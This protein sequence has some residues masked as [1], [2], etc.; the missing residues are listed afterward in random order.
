M[1]IPCDEGQDTGVYLTEEEQTKLSEN[2]D[3]LTAVMYP[4]RH[5]QFPLSCQMDSDGR[6]MATFIDRMMST[7]MVFK[8]KES[9]V[10]PTG[11]ASRHKTKVS[12]GE[13]TDVQWNGFPAWFEQPDL[14]KL[15]CQS[16][17]FAANFSDQNAKEAVLTRLAKQKQ[18][19]FHMWAEQK[20]KG[21]SA[22]SSSSMQPPPVSKTPSD[23]AAESVVEDQTLP[24]A[25]GGKEGLELAEEQMREAQ[26]SVEKEKA[27][28]ALQAA[29]YK[30]ESIKFVQAIN[31]YSVLEDNL[32]KEPTFDDPQGKRVRTE[33]TKLFLTSWYKES[34]E[35]K[36]L[37]DELHAKNLC[38][39]GKGR[40]FHKANPYIPAP[41]KYKD[42]YERWYY[43]IVPKQTEQHTMKSQKYHID[44]D[45]VGSTV[46][47]SVRGDQFYSTLLIPLS[48]NA[49]E[50]GTEVTTVEQTDIKTLTGA[51][52]KPQGPTE[53]LNK[54]GYGTLFRGGAWHRGTVNNNMDRPRVMLMQ[55]LSTKEKDENEENDFNEEEERRKKKKKPSTPPRPKSKDAQSS[56]G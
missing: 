52:Q 27:N 11:R 41:E 42:L 12:A 13:V 53:I 19:E 35:F 17:A 50:G 22:A 20:S 5:V 15:V 16:R 47:S 28:A 18:H 48:F 32:F 8:R 26:R 24:V 29:T 54:F 33:M 49:L 34:K 9:H 40:I 3:Y 31:D 38:G 46:H 30:E 1:R 44:S 55:V 10:D 6:P 37:I 56:S 14:L 36:S 45:E 39:R 21:N 7:P 23:D 25:G 43:M 2:Q 51:D 4:D